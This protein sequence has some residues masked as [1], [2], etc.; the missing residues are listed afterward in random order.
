M[1][2][3]EY[4]KCYQCKKIIIK[5]DNGITTGYGLDENDNKICFKCCGINDKEYMETHDKITLYLSHDKVDENHIKWKI[6]NWPGSFVLDNL[7]VSHGSH[8]WGLKR[9][10]VWVA[11]NGVW[12]YGIQI[13]DNTQLINLRRTKEVF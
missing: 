7:W 4:M 5:P 1:Y 10:N 9:K 8:N 3:G 6:T 2:G 12:W 13:G 11:F